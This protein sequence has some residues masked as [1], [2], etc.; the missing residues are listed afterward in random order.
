MRL[1]ETSC[2]TAKKKKNKNSESF[3]DFVLDENV[4]ANLGAFLRRHG[5]DCIDISGSVMAGSPDILVAAVADENGAILI[6]FDKDMKAI[7][8]RV[9]DTS[10]RRFKKLGRI[11][12]RCDGHSL[13]KRIE[14]CFDFI[15]FE[16]RVAQERR[17][18]RMFLTIGKS[19]IRSD[20]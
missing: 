3:M 2:P 13:V 16:F 6:S 11:Y 20:R 5:H 14:S 4:P 18:K 19:Y 9:P 15:E 7:A 17:D 12:L 1:P 8:A 10:R